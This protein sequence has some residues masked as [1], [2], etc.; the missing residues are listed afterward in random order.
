[1]QLHAIHSFTGSR[2]NIAE[3]SDSE[4]VWVRMAEDGGTGSSTCKLCIAQWEGTFARS[5]VLQVATLRAEVA[6]CMRETGLMSHMNL[7]DVGIGRTVE[8][9]VGH[10]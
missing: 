4:S 9:R 5:E 6:C 3:H 2:Y 8:G 1:M 7:L 10:S